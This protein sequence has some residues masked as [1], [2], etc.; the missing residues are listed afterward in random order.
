MMYSIGLG[1][2]QSSGR[3]PCEVCHKGVDNSGQQQHL[4]HITERQTRKCLIKVGPNKLEMVASICYLGDVLSI[5]SGCKLA[6]SI[7]VKTVR[8]T[9]RELLPVL[10]FRYL[11]CKSCGYV[12]RSCTWSPILIASEF[13]PFAKAIIQHLQHMAGLCSSI[14]CLRMWPQ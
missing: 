11:S 10:T 2:L 9:L 6:V 7:H 8:N 5:D 12:Y 1:L 13:W 14:P 3:F 4:Q